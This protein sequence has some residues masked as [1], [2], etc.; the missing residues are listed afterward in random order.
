[1]V[2]ISALNRDDERALK[3]LYDVY[4]MKL[5]AIASNRLDDDADAE[6]CVQDVFIGLWRNRHKINITHSLNAYLAAAVK[7]Q[8]FNRLAKRYTKKHNINFQP[9]QVS[10][11]SA[12]SKLLEQ[13]LFTSL[14]A[15]IKELP[16]KC[17]MVYRMS[18]LEGKTNSMIAAELNVSQKT[19]EGHMTKAIL[20][21]KKRF[22][23]NTIPIFLSLLEWYLF[24]RTK[25]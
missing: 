13:D 23:S 12:D 7:N 16:E 24:F 14:E 9:E 1:M 6:E 15:A 3:E 21:I 22:S 18:R 10:N 17:Q 2:L 5:L 19:V 4:W 25:E 11:I 20:S 8:V